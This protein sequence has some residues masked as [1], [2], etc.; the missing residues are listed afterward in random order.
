MPFRG[1]LYICCILLG[2]PSAMRWKT[3]KNPKRKIAESVVVG[4]HHHH[5]GQLDLC[6]IRL[7]DCAFV[8]ALRP[9]L[10]EHWRAWALVCARIK[11]KVVEIQLQN[12]TAVNIDLWPWPL[13]NAHNYFFCQF[14]CFGNQFSV[15][16][17]I[18]RWD[19]IDTYRL[20]GVSGNMRTLVGTVLRY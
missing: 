15:S 18:C 9:V 14:A 8:L 16:G 7:A 19:K 17:S 1:Y 13:H 12:T 10:E 20:I 3:P 2:S 5:T 6:I 4:H 11:D